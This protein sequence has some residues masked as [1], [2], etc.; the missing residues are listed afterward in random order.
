MTTQARS[1]FTIDKKDESPID[2]LGG[3]M[4]KARWRKTFAGDLTGTSEIEFL[5]ARLE[6]G[7]MAYVGVERFEGELSGRRGTFVLTHASTMNGSDYEMIVKIVPGS[8]TGELSGISGIAEITPDH[9]LLLNYEI[10][11]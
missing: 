8:G 4:N 9:D 10:A 5:M 3:S 2:W 7:A 6:T 11:S 1:S